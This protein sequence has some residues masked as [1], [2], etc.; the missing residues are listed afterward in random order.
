[1]HCAK[2]DRVEGQG[3]MCI[4]CTPFSEEAHSYGEGLAHAVNDLE[5]QAA[6]QYHEARRAYL[7]V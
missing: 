5:V 4:K 6:L 1:M 3:S 7:I 2:R